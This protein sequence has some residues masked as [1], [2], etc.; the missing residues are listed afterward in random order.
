MKKLVSTIAMHLLFL[1]GI[2]VFFYFISLS[3]Q[4]A[5]VEQFSSQV[6]ERVST[7]EENL[8]VINQVSGGEDALSLLREEVNMLRGRFVSYEMVEDVTRELAAWAKQTDLQPVRVIPPIGREGTEFNLGTES[9]LHVEE[10]P[11]VMEVKGKYL[12]YGRFIQSLQQF[13]YHIT[14]GGMKIA[15]EKPE[16][17]NM[18]IM[19][20][21][22]IFV[23]REGFDYES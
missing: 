12:D 8:E 19:S 15:K 7:I 13:P 16:D 14:L 6:N 9:T 20:E 23:I 10:Y 18:S 5:S 21:F 17:S 3:P 11:I 22:K 4:R 1:S 2:F